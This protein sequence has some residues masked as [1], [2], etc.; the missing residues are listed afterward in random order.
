MNTDQAY[1]HQLQRLTEQ[2]KL[3]LNAKEH[4]IGRKL[5]PYEVVQLFGLEPSGEVKPR[6]RRMSD[7]VEHWSEQF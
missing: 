4:D 2:Q 1:A 5:L 3:I 6:K 7:E